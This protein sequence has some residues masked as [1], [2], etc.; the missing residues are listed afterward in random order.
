LTLKLK[1][2][3]SQ[4][5]HFLFIELLR[6]NVERAK[7]RRGQMEKDKKVNCIKCKFYY[8][9]WNSQQPRGCRIFRFESSTMPCYIVK[10]ETGK[11]C[12]AYRKKEHGFKSKD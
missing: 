10:K 11:P 2:K 3:F 4:N 6:Y 9:T 1:G 5:H 12:E 8:A 7:T